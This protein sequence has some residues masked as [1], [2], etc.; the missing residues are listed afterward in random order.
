MKVTVCGAAGEVTGSGYLVETNQACVL[1]D[2]GMFQG[3]RA[4]DERNRDL[5]PVDPEKLDAI[6]ATHAHLDH[7]GR[8]PLLAKHK[9]RAPIYGTPATGDFASLILADSANIQESDARRET[10]RAERAG[11]KPVE[12]LYTS[13][14]AEKLAP[15]F[16]PI[17][18]GER[19]E[20]APGI[21]VRL[22][23]AGH[24]LGSS[25]AEMTLTEGGVTKTIVFSGD[26]GPRDVPFMRNPV[27]FEKADLVFLESTYGGREHRSLD[28]TVAE[29]HDIIEGALR[30]RTKV[31][32][33]TFAIGRAQQILYYLAEL[34][35]TS[36]LSDFPI[37]LDS[38][39]AIRATELYWKHQDLFDRDATDLIADR[40]FRRDLKN[41]KF[42]LR[43]EDSMKL[44]ND[45]APGVIMAG[46]GMCNG[47]RILHHFR[48][49]LW[50][51]NTRVMFVG[52]QG[53]GT[54][55]NQL[56][57]GAEYVRIFGERIRVKAQMHT[58]GGFSAHAGA[59]ELVEWVE[60]LV[61]SGARVVLT[62][63]EED[64]RK[65]LSD[66][67]Q[68]RYG[69]KAQRPLQGDVIKL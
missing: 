31:L 40:A 44:N 53:P 50:R 36:D 38:P 2:F 32:I 45:K 59:T 11:R 55:G 68:E 37:Y 28:D 29:F 25:S 57:N 69:V 10:R 18:Y 6:L 1:V 42:L 62:H 60:P 26:I 30:A 12:P 19:R 66:R 33:P 63:G 17:D 39:M 23:D 58:L 64:S 22:V 16:E 27:L 21:Q 48:N 9:F 52:F 34:I 35:R 67:L 15:L 24:I 7:T 49:H 3:R 43:A 14:D 47:G 51:K 20:I 54:L 5:G 46:A 13:R 41:L 56:V 65:A 4:T 8:L 61:K